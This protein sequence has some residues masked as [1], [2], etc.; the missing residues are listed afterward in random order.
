MSIEIDNITKDKHSLWVEISILFNNIL[1]SLVGA[2]IQ[3]VISGDKIVIHKAFVVSK[4]LGQL[5][6]YSI[7]F[8]KPAV[9]VIGLLSLSLAIVVFSSR[10]VRPS[11]GIANILLAF[12]CMLTFIM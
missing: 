5:V 9:A 11:F 4:E 7:R 3:I 10:I 6:S 2:Y 1:I 12:M 8:P